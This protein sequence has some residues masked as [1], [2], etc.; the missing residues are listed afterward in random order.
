VPVPCNLIWRPEDAYGIPC[1]GWPTGLN[2]RIALPVQAEE[3]D[4]RVQIG[5]YSYCIFVFLGCQCHACSGPQVRVLNVFRVLRYVW[6][7]RIRRVGRNAGDEPHGSVSRAAPSAETLSPEDCPAAPRDVV[8][9]TGGGD[10]C[11]CLHQC[12]DCTSFLNPV[13]LL[14]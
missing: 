4:H 13:L 6:Q 11:R 8:S 14:L 12:K 5:N 10:P 2:K 1:T 3:W 9:S 7:V